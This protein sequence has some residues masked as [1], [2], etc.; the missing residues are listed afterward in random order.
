MSKRL[1]QLQTLFDKDAADPFLAYGIA[2]EHGKAGRLDDA[3][4]W[5]DRTLQIDSHYCYAYFQKAK[6]LDQKGDPDAARATLRDGITAAQSA[7]DAHAAE[8]MMQLMQS[9]E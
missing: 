9:M 5:L 6:M 1:E 3:I 2:I 7:G 4:A 8:E